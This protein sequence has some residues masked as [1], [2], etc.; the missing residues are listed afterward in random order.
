MS[1]KQAEAKTKRV[2]KTW[3]KKEN[4]SPKWLALKTK[5]RAEKK[6]NERL[7]EVGI[8]TYL[9]LTKELKQWSDR[10][11]WVKEPMFR[12]YI[13]V[14]VV[15]TEYMRVLEQEGAV[16]FI[17]FNQEY[18]T[19]D[20]EQIDFIRKII[21]NELRYEVTEDEFEPGDMIEVINGPLKGFKGEWVMNKSKY[22][23]A[24]HIHQ[25]QRTITVEIPVAFIKKIS[26]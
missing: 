3:A 15:S 12:G 8:E 14:R 10:R 18:A 1:K 22:N 11:K 9:P 2:I 26:E 19:I 23:V 7:M 24:V 13:F 20:E 5:P 25:L 6:L 16:H 4:E 21:N 17:K